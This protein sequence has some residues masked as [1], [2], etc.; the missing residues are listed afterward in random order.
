LSSSAICPEEERVEQPQEQ[1]I[2]QRMLGILL[3]HARQRAS[4]SQADLAASL[5]ISTSRYAQYEHGQREPLLSE[6]E[7]VAE[8]CDVPLGFFFDDQASVEDEGMRVPQAA[9]QRIRQK[10]MGAQ[11]HQ[12]RQ[13]VGKSQKEV[14]EA[15]GIPAR[16]VS[17]YESGDRAIPASELTA[18]ASYLNMDPGH[19]QLAPGAEG[20]D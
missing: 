15:L 11:L 19:F 9:A 16:H 3:R 18:L 2:R 6:L 12:A 5:H 20:T 8:L 17:E 1:M 7:V 4:R 14:A 13:C 10:M